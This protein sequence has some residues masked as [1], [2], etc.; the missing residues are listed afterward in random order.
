MQNSK[1]RKVLNYKY[2]WK[3]YLLDKIIPS[4]L[5]V[6]PKEEAG[7]A[8]VGGVEWGPAQADKEHGPTSLQFLSPGPQ[9][10]CQVRLK[11]LPVSLRRRLVCPVDEH[12]PSVVRHRSSIHHRLRH[13]HLNHKLSLVFLPFSS[14]FLFIWL[15]RSKKHFQTLLYSELGT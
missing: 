11:L 5:K 15:I 13:L 12:S 14:F 7:S 6:G 4:I 9:K 10:P 2:I 1:K 8:L 3:W